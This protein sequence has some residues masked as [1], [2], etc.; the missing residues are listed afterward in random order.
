MECLTADV[1]DGNV[2]VFI[3]G[4]TSRSLSDLSPRIHPITSVSNSCLLTG[5]SRLLRQDRSIR[6]QQHTASYQLD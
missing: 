6:P 5:I 3:D 4:Y 2:E 1:A